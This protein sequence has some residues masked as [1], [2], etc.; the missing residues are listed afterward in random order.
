M[1]SP[2][3]SEFNI[4]TRTTEEDNILQTT[5]RHKYTQTERAKCMRDVIDIQ[6]RVFVHVEN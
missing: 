6:R 5:S 3:W 2:P 4:H 1:L